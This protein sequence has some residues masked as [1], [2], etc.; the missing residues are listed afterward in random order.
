MSNAQWPST[1]DHSAASDAA[2]RVPAEPTS[3]PSQ[4][5]ISP[6]LPI[7]FTVLWILVCPIVIFLG[8]FSVFLS[9]S[10]TSTPF[11]M[12]FYGFFA[13]VALCPLSIIATWIAWGTTRK[14]PSSGPKRVA[15]IVSYCLPFIGILTV[16]L[17]FVAIQ[18]TC[19]GALVCD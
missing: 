5:T 6:V 15:R 19:G 14:D 10:G 17:G 9:D 7:L 16:I 11:Y 4:D 3:Q 2:L 12:I 8:F 1:P 13:T 18:T